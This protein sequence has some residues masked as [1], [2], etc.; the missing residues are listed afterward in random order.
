M[1]VAIVECDQSWA[2]RWDAYA[3]ANPQASL[4]HLWKWLDVTRETFGHRT[5]AVAAVEGERVRGIFP[6][7]QVKTLIFGNI[8]C[9]MPFVNF[10]G[11]SSETQDIESALLDY[12]GRLAA[13]ERMAYLEIRSNRELHGYPSARHKVSLTVDLPENPDT[14]WAAFKTS[15]RQDVRKPIKA[16]F[17]VRH[18]GAELIDDFYLVLLESW[19]D[20]GTPFYP[21]SYFHAL[22]RAL[23][24]RLWF[25]VVYQGAEPAAAQLSGMFQQTAE[26][27][28]LGTREQFRR[29]YAGYLLYWE[30][31]KWA[32]EHGCRRYH[33]GR[34]TADS[35]AEAFKK[36][37]NAYA[38]PLYWHYWLRDGQP[39]PQ[40]NVTNPKFQ[41]AI[42]AW[43]QLP[44]QVVGRLGPILARGIP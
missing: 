30:I 14:L 18:G 3:E 40:L 4:Y 24:T 21:K 20:L 32:S 5:F 23:G 22:W 10:G 27:M 37:W 43:R 35:G 9:S 42:A 26:G 33:L 19:R 34:S 38:A 31:L 11:P 29:A 7:V 25:S 44:L 17:V 15:H 36:K 41:L 8:G 6:I 1:S 39:M 13:R 12:G 16:G 28:W 2:E